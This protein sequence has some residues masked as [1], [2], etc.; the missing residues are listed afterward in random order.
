MAVQTLDIKNLKYVI[1]G[2]SALILILDFVALIFVFLSFSNA[3]FLVIL[4]SIFQFLAI[5]VC[6]C[7]A[8]I[9]LWSAFFNNEKVLK[10]A[11]WNCAI[12]VG[13]LLQII[14]IFLCMFIN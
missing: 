2:M 8:L 10:F 12:I 14:W 7:G 5:T 6:A 4:V 3:P 11:Y 13:I 9:G 1:M